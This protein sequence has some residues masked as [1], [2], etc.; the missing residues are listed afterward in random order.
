MLLVYSAHC[1][2]WSNITVHLCWK[3]WSNHRLTAPSSNP[4]VHTPPTHSRLVAFHMSATLSVCSC[5]LWRAPVSFIVSPSFSS[6][7]SLFPSSCRIPVRVIM[8]LILPQVS[9]P[10]LFLPLFVIKIKINQ[11]VLMAVPHHLLGYKICTAHVNCV[12]MRKQKLISSGLT[13]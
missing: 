11:V 1:P 10:S 9:F 5:Q 8:L 12:C 4:A 13:R 7:I 2:R 3:S 6:P